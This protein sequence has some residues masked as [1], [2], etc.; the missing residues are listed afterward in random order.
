MRNAFSRELFAPPLRVRVCCRGGVGGEEPNPCGEDETCG[1]MGGVEVAP[2]AGDIGG[3]VDGDIG[4]VPSW[5]GELTCLDD[6]FFEKKPPFI[7][8]VSLLLLFFF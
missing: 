7:N 1:D 2:N 3:G 4:G 6:F 5:A 8:A